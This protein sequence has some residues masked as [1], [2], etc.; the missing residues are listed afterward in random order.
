[1][2]L[3]CTSRSTAQQYFR[4]HSAQLY[5]ILK[6]KFIRIRSIFAQ[7]YLPIKVPSGLIAA[8]S[9]VRVISSVGR[10]PALQAGWRRFDSVIT[11]QVFVFVP[12]TE[13]RAVVAQLVR[14]P[15]CHAGGRGF[16][17]RPPRQK[18]KNPAARRDFLWLAFY[19]INSFRIMCV[20]VPI[21]C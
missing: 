7:K 3:T 14:V 21:D 8:S 16:E 10:A 18:I 12:R 5:F 6:P 13:T 17:P 15:A 19:Q 1:M 11:H 4:Q 2:C 9:D 20:G